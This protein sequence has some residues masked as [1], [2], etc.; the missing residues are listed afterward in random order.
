MTHWGFKDWF[1]DVFVSSIPFILGHNEEVT[2]VLGPQ[3]FGVVADSCGQACY[4]CVQ[5]GELVCGHPGGMGPSLPLE[6]P[7]MVSLT[8]GQTTQGSESIDQG[9]PACTWWWQTLWFVVSL[10]PGNPGL[11][12]GSGWYIPHGSPRGPATWLPPLST[13]P[14]TVLLPSP[15]TE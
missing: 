13:H 3:V 2:M 15:P 12:P 14:H 5:L 8:N 1:V 10:T 7:Q 11:C 6:L 9:S 4:Q